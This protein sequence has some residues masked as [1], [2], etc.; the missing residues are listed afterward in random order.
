MLNQSVLTDPG[1]CPH[2]LN[3]YASIM[4]CGNGYMGI[5]ATHEEDYTQQTRGMYLAGLYHRA[6]RNETTELI[7]LPDVTGIDIEL[8]GVN[9][10]LLSGEILEWQR[11]L[12]FA[13][14]E[15][16]R[17]VVW[18]SPDGKRYRLE[19]RR[20]VSLDQLP[21]VAMQLSIT[22]LDGAAQAVLKTG[23]DAT[24]TNSGRQH[25]DEIS[26]RVFD[27][28]YMQ[29]VY[30]TQDRAS[31]V[32]VSAFCQLSAKSDSCF[33]AKNRRLSVHH[34]LT[35]SQG[36][37]VTLEKI[38][39]LT[40]RCDKSLSQE[41]FARNA[42][43]DLKVCAARGYDALLESSAYAWEAVWRDARVEVTCAEQQDQ[44]A[45]DYAVWHLTTMTPAH[46]ER[47][48]IAAKGLTGEGY[49]GHVFWDTEIFLLPFHLFTRPQIARSLLRYR[50]LNLSG[51]REKARRNGW[52]GAL[53]PWESAA[54]GQEETPEFA[55]INIRTGVRQKV[56]SA[57][58]EHHIVADIAW[59]VVAYWQATHDDAF[60]RNE[61]LTLLMETASFWM[62]RATEINGRLEIHDVIGPDEY[63]KHVNNNAYTN[64][65]AWHNVACARQFMA[66][67]GR[68]D[69]RFTENAGAFLARL[70]LPEADAE[71]VIPQDDT[72]MAKPAIDLSRYK[73]KAGKQTILLDYSRAEVNE[74]QILKQ[75]DVVM[76]NYLL[77]ERFT[78]QQCA[79]N[80]AFYEPRTIH[81][82]SL[83]KAIHG[84]V[85][86][87][88]GDTD[89]AYAFW[90]DGIAIDLG[91]DP[92][93]SD[94]GIHAAATGAIWLGAIQ[95]FAGL[96][97]SEGELH[98]APKLPAHWQKLAFPLRW[99]NATMHVTCEDDQL[100]IETT[101]PVT[102]TLWGKT[103]HV[104][105][106]KVCARKDFLAS[107]NGTATTEG[108]HDA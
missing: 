84:I 61:G 104:S 51:A 47:S 4:A 3:K 98:L 79:A 16:H 1:F 44:L 11:E 103:L 30:E 93:S 48:S 19:S 41:S 96:H 15:L 77:P 38:V 18:R 8:D 97:I 75:A 90:R 31:E 36:D 25:L 42:L 56:A 71:G 60:M 101:A 74:M 12:A 62:G 73:A 94:D 78:P 45:L 6:G 17:N 107:V 59:A 108:R 88:C 24:Q 27:Q 66:M 5:R 26:V 22:P 87:R 72:F 39:W 106:R 102:L 91:D 33:T 10:T 63:T 43:A 29:G 54:S 7:N 70:W 67:F 37:T 105:G 85:L 82:S 76:L 95:G 58:A 81:D 64:Y 65:L 34:S 99:R 52:P 68:E 32:V 57:L 40:Q 86:A 28:H 20:F 9:F 2:S 13:N 83:S 35:I 55:A 53:F 50:W 46:D 49:K 23:I 100:T 69:A 21:L 14:G 92:H 89:G 80:L